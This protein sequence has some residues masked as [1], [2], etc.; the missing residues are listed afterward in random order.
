[1]SGSVKP[2]LF[3]WMLLIYG[4]KKSVIFI[5]TTNQKVDPAARLGISYQ[6][7]C[8]YE[9]ARNRLPAVYVLRIAKVLDIPL[10]FL[11][12]NDPDDPFGHAGL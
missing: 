12:S 11:L 3:L 1:M 4:A 2:R 8:K 7:I 6:Q 10:H 9:T 5:I